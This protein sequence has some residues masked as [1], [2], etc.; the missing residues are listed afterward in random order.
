M[1]ALQQFLRPEFIN[2]VD[3]VICF[4]QLFGGEFPRIARIRLGGC[5]EVLGKESDLYLGR[6]RAGSVGEG[7]YSAA[8]GAGTCAGTFRK[9]WRTPLLTKSSRVISIHHRVKGRGRGRRPLSFTLCTAHKR[10]AYL[11]R[12]RGVCLP[13][14]SEKDSPG[15]VG[16][17]R[18]LPLSLLSLGAQ[19]K[20]CQG[21]Q[22]GV[23]ANHRAHIP[24]GDRDH[25]QPLLDHRRQS[26][27]LVQTVSMADVNA[28]I[29]GGLWH[30]PPCV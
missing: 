29:L 24:N 20:K 1:K 19:E 21:S 28:L 23:G 2:R 22:A 3:E 17:E 26:P 8:Y 4:N 10:P 6:N 9:T 5:K 27:R 25:V 7:F 11:S 18:N 15:C 12:M 14:S 13:I 16:I 30:S